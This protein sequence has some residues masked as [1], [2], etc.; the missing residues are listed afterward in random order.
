MPNRLLFREVVAARKSTDE[1]PTGLSLTGVI[2]RHYGGK[3]LTEQERK[4]LLEA[5]RET[6]YAAASH[7]PLPYFTDEQ[8]TDAMK[9]PGAVFDT[10]LSVNCVAASVLYAINHWFRMFKRMP[11]TPPL[12][13]YRFQSFLWQRFLAWDRDITI[14]PVNHCRINPGAIAKNFKPNVDGVVLR[15]GYRSATFTPGLG[16]VTRSGGLSHLCQ[17]M[18]APANLYGRRCWMYPFIT[19][20]SSTNDQQE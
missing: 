11:L 16:T 20:R 13:I 10:R 18:G 1:A 6:I 9:Q 12:M 17:K 3:T 8:A 15:D 4:S 19:L 14:N 5:L 7:K 2:I